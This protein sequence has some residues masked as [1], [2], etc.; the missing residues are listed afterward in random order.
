MTIASAARF[1]KMTGD[2]P[3]FPTA[4]YAA[5]VVDYERRFQRTLEAV[6]GVL[7]SSLAVHLELDD[8]R[9]FAPAGGEDHIRG[10]LDEL[11]R[12]DP[13]TDVDWVIG[14]AGS[15]PRFEDSFH[16]LGMGEV[17]GKHVVLRA[18]ND[19]AEY[20]AIQ[21]GFTELSEAERDKLIRTR[22]EHKTAVVL[23]HEL[24]HTLGALH[25]LDKTNIMNPRYS[26]SVRRFD[27]QTIE[28][29]GAVLL[30]RT[31][32]GTLALRCLPAGAGR[33]RA[34]LQHRHATRIV[35]GGDAARVRRPDSRLVPRRIAAAA[36]WRAACTPVPV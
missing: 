23:L 1:A 4:T 32:S 36:A 7:E 26:T 33:R 11:E 29:M 9:P 35:V 16:E 22:L 10:L 31:D 8:R 30:H 5:Q 21:A 13:G 17:V 20:K 12:I 15:V 24:V 34:P 28:V 6:N 19:V 2:G 14:L 27:A 3:G 25:E 18:L